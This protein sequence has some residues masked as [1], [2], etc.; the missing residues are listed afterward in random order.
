MN[1]NP[2]HLIDWYKADH[3]RQYPD[4]TSFVFSNFTP[5]STRMNGVDKIAFFGLQYFIKEYLIKQWNEKFFSRPKE[6]VLRKY[7]RRV[8]NALG[9]DAAD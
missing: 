9:K 3:R 5:R 2:L 4:S 1:I 7:K 8:N 6:E